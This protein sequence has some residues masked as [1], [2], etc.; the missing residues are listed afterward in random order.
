MKKTFIIIATFFALGVNA[1]KSNK[2]IKGDEYFELYSYNSAINKYE[3]VSELT[4]DG[5]R[6]LAEAY[7]N[8][9]ENEKSELAYSDFIN[10]SDVLAEDYYNYASILRINGKYDESNTWMKKFQEKNPTDLRAKS[11]VSNVSELTNLLKDQ[12]KYKIT[13]LDINTTSQD[14]GP[15]FYGNQIVFNSTRHGVASIKRNYNWNNLPF[16]DLYVADRSEDGEQL[17]NPGQLNKKFNNKLHDGQASFAKGATE[18]VFTRNNYSDESSD[19]IIKLKL[20]FATKNENGEWS[21]ETPFKLNNAEYSVGHPSI[22]EDGNVMYFSSDMP[23]GFGGSDIYRIIKDDSGN[24]GEAIN[25]G[26]NVNTEGNEMFPFF[27][28]DQKILFFASNGQMGLGGLDIFISPDYGEGEFL[29]VLNAGTP[30]NTKADDFGLI[31]DE[32]MRKGYFSSNREGGQGNDD[33]YGFELLSPFVFKKIIKG[34]AK[35]ENGNILAGT[36]VKLLDKNNTLIQ[37]IITSDK[38][39]YVFNVADKTEYILYGDKSTYVGDK[40]HPNTNGTS[41]KIVSDLTLI[42]DGDISLLAK[43]TDKKTGNPI[44]G[45]KVTLV[46]KITKAEKGYTTNTEGTFTELLKD[47][48]IRDL[49]QY[50]IILEKEGYP[51]KVVTYESE[52][53]RAG[54]YN[55]SEAIDMTLDI[56]AEGTTSDLIVINPIYFDLDS[57]DLRPDAQKELDKIITLMNTYP[58]MAIEL[59]S[60]TD[61]RATEQYNMVLS[62]RRAKSSAQYIK[63]QIKNPKRIYGKGY[64]ESHLIKEGCSCENEPIDGGCADDIH[65]VNRRT[66]FKVI[67]SKIKIKNTSSK[68]F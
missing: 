52:F 23:G 68:S 36:E 30:L 65:E 1:Q 2:E 47:K 38:G 43:I 55:I 28:E 13:F 29:N 51:T 11:Y 7:H 37:S 67:K 21:D 4:S 18:M 64:G 16:L 9:D 48:K 49:A 53:N 60:F 46:D 40:K 15:A 41:K 3:S 32:K 12:G 59:G 6:K 50:D 33:I 45:V 27:Q 63:K 42:K 25:L 10:N 22:S 17:S 62:S 57:Y 31:V 35:D 34:I 39:T 19:E 20:F 44:E 58:D 14:F 26:E 8:I 56:N 66:E 24:W 54:V 5:Q 61:C